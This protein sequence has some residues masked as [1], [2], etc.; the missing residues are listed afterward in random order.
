MSQTENTEP[1]YT[2][3]ELHQRIV[4]LLAEV[5][6]EQNEIV[7]AMRSCGS[8]GF[9]CG[10][11]YPVTRML[12]PYC[13]RL[14]FR[15][16]RS[17]FLLGSFRLKANMVFHDIVVT[18]KEAAP[19][20]FDEIKGV[21]DEMLSGLD[22]M[23]L[24]YL[25]FQELTLTDKGSESFWP[26]L[27]VITDRPID[28]QAPELPEPPESKDWRSLLQWSSEYQVIKAHHFDFDVDYQEPKSIAQAFD[29]LSYVVKPMASSWVKIENPS[30]FKQE[31]RFLTNYL[32]P[33]KDQTQMMRAGGVFHF[34]DLYQT[35]MDGLLNNHKINRSV[36]INDRTFKQRARFLIA[37]VA[38]WLE[39]AK[40]YKPGQIAA[41][42][43][44]KGDERRIREW[45][46]KFA[47]E[48][49]SLLV[50]AGLVA[51]NEPDWDGLS[52]QERDVVV[53]A[54]D[55]VEQNRIHDRV[56]IGSSQVGNILRK[57][58]LSTVGK[59]RLAGVLLG[60]RLHGV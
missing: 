29:R 14:R 24:N 52:S 8:G 7:Q 57:Y 6:G 9:Y 32:D 21:F 23:G 10:K 44:M 28:N 34:Q 58:D 18:P 1:E 47:T 59:R 11:I 3:E 41:T 38:H 5:M 16:A 40:G 12:C 51:W 13:H 33:I 17:L 30:R 20:D 49:I 50:R 48:S 31:L 26:H 35:G 39:L 56:E 55:Q 54:I 2:A 25:A 27:H 46:A 60:D 37:L 22:R 43:K 53:T 36:N 15:L 45:K 42:L 19:E 4:K